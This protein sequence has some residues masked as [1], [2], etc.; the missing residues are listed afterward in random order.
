MVGLSLGLL[1]GSSVGKVGL[2]SVR[3]CVCYTSLKITSCPD[4][5]LRVV[6]KFYHATQVG[7]CCVAIVF[8]A[9][10]FEAVIE[11]YTHA[12]LDIQV[13]KEMTSNAG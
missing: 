5:F 8:I 6:T 11:Y 9:D 2:Q 3:Q 7:V 12:E 1:V 10:N 13:L 4:D